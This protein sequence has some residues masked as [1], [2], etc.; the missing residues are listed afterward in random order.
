M[1]MALKLVLMTFEHTHYLPLSHLPLL[2]TVPN[3]D[4]K[5]TP[6]TVLEKIQPGSTQPLLPEL[7]AVT[8]GQKHD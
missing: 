5:L 8:H 4:T 2:P 7:N 6:T 3:V 1:Q